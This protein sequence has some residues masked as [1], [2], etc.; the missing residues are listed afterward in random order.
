MRRLFKTKVKVVS[1]DNEVYYDDNKVRIHQEE[2]DLG[3]TPQQEACRRSAFHRHY[4]NGNLWKY[5]CIECVE[6]DPITG[7]EL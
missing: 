1:P 4:M 7:K 5:H 6:L 2:L 3:T